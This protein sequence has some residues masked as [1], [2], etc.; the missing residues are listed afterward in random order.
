[1]LVG[2]WKS[3]RED[4]PAC[5]PR[6]RTAIAC[7]STAARPAAGLAA[8]R[9]ARTEAMLHTHHQDRHY[10]A[11]LERE[12]RARSVSPEELA[13]VVRRANERD[14]AAWSVLVESFA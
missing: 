9:P 8:R 12:R 4:A 3:R 7:S 2:S 5:A 6:A 10:I 13:V 11:A 1:M 14:R